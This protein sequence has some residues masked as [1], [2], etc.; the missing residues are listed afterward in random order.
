VP[1]GST[2]S[3]ITLIL[4]SAGVALFHRI[5]NIYC[6]VFYH[7]AYLI[8]ITYQVSISNL[9][10]PWIIFTHKYDTADGILDLELVPTHT[11]SF[12]TK[13]TTTFVT[14]GPDFRSQEAMRTTGT[15][16]IKG[17]ILVDP[18]EYDIR[19]AI[20]AKDNK[21]FSNPIVSTFMLLPKVSTTNDSK[22]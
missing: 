14:W 8:S 9:I 16:H 21:I 6:Y 20:V 22:R 10:R 4:S 19:V 1:T 12:P 5:S 15:Y 18:S 3:S 13:A 2:P 11:I 7:I 17:P